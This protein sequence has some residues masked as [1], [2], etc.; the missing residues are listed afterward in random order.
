VSDAIFLNTQISGPR[1]YFAA[2]SAAVNA[3][4][5]TYG[6][7]YFDFSNALGPNVTEPLKLITGLAGLTY[8]PLGMAHHGLK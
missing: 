6:S 4:H 2:A 5:V 1:A 8:L 7:R 3:K